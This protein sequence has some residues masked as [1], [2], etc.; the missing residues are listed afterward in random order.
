MMKT[1]K[2][3]ETITLEKTFPG[4][5]PPAVA[6]PDAPQSGFAEKIAIVTGGGRGIG[7][8]V[9][10]QLIAHGAEMVALFD[11]KQEA[12]EKAVTSLDKTHC[13]PVAVDVTDEEQVKNAVT[14]IASRY[15]RIDLLANM[16]GIPGPSARV[17]NYSFSAFKHV[18]AV[19][20][21]G[22][23]LM[24]KYCLPYMQKNRYGTIVNTCSCSGMRGYALEIGYGSSKSAVLG[25]TMN[26]ANENGGNGV[27][28]N[29]V[30]PGWVNT[31]MLDDILSQYA[32]TKD[33]GYTKETLRN[34]TMNRPSTPD[35][36]ANVVRFL[37]SDDARYVNGANFV[38]D[39]GKT[40]G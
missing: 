6:P 34:G 5:I 32:D 18:Y 31:G 30:S 39:G 12:L 23:F 26:A 28:V 2:T 9:A 22:T 37:L 27:R 4:N 13:Y 15:G 20:V 17:E 21:F 38:C 24:M 35:E 1:T 3:P 16:A 14:Q 11:L 33:G 29:C 36:V 8:A 40:L 25:M 10:R 7:F 19:N